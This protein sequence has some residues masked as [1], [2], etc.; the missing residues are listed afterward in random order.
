LLLLAVI[1]AF[2]LR[3]DVDI[4][5]L[6]PGNDSVARGLAAY[7]EKFL[8]AGELIVVLRSE[9]AEKTLRAV[10]G[11]AAAIARQTNLVER[12]FW[13]PPANDSLADSA[14]FLAYL[15]LNGPTNEVSEWHA[16]LSPERLD[17]TLAAS[18][19]RI[20]TSFSP[21]DLFIAPRDPL[22]LSEAAAGAEETFE[23]P[24]KFFASADGFTRFIYLYSAVPLE[25]MNNAGSGFGK[26][27]RSSRWL[28]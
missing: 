4:L 10:Q 26:S 24:E 14:K 6:L 12:F 7:Q 25:T 2:R 16:A 15:W 23:A 3:I 22:G 17:S 21:R 28:C 18:R 13:Q 8:Q 9:D 5:N 19:E 27:A 11:V 1:G 20:A